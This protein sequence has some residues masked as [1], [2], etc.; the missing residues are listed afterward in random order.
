MGH[1]LVKVGRG[2]SLDKVAT[3]RVEEFDKNPDLDMVMVVE[4]ELL[5]EE[6][7]GLDGELVL[8][9][10]LSLWGKFP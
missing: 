3:D 9:Y 5:K 1:K 6:F 4:G 7:S 8:Q 10:E 2:L